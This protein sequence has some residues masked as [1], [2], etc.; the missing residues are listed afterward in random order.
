MTRFEEHPGMIRIVDVYDQTTREIPIDKVP[1]NR[2]FVYLRHGVEVSIPAEA[3][4]RYPIVEIRMI[5]IDLHGNLVSRE[6]AAKLVVEE[7]G[8]KGRP[9]R[10]TTMI[11][12]RIVPSP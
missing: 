5:S 3:T 7:Y 11:A 6:H 8:P 4:S 9:L 10:H 2:R 12:N 1:A